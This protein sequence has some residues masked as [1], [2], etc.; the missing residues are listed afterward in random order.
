[1]LAL[2]AVLV[3]SVTGG[4]N[5]Q[6]PDLR[7]TWRLVSYTQQLADTGQRAYIFGEN[8]QGTLVIDDNDS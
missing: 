3:L 6:A 2:V 5:A 1:L 8:P 7:G 4:G